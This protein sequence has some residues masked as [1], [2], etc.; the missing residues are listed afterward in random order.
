MRQPSHILIVDDKAE[1]RDLLSQLL[2]DEH[3]VTLAADG[4]EAIAAI[5]R[6]RPD[7]LLLDLLMPKVDGFAVLK[8]LADHP[9]PF[10]P[11][12]VRSAASQRGVRVKA[13]SMG[14][15]EFLGTP[16]DEEELRIR[17]RSMLA[18][19][20]ARETAEQRA[21][22][23]EVTVAERTR[24]LRLALDDLRRSNHYKDEFLSVIS[25][26]LR[27][28]LGAIIAYAYSLDEGLA[29]ELSQPQRDM[30]EQIVES[31]N[32]MMGLVSDLVDMSLLAAG[33]LK[34]DFR[35]ECYAPLVAQAVEGLRALAEEK[36]ITLATEVD[37]PEPV[38]LDDQR[39]VQVLTNLVQNALN[40]T[41]AG[42]KVVI[43]AFQREGQLVTEVTD[44][45]IGIA[46]DDM[47]RLFKQFTQVDMSSTRSVGGFGLGLSLAKAIVEAHGGKIGVRSVPGEGST[48]WF[49]LPEHRT[50]EEAAR[51]GDSRST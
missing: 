12:I 45:G 47:S 51:A 33:K 43:R 5:T 24:E 46:P 20:E 40:F 3:H 34:V 16:F 1:T 32:R 28:P 48:F 2:E 26:E 39:T 31:G 9:G 17:I 19:K 25:H 15:H 41:E 22:D 7:L 44:T 30:V 50:A 36:E 10:L 13:L 37:A 49:A 11:V 38:S 4:A 35:E 42:G 18:L 8:H 29:G 6:D 27:T 23:L 14:A 21:R